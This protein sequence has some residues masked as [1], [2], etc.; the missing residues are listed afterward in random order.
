MGRFVNPDNS[1]FEAAVSANIYVDKP[2]L[3]VIPTELLI[4][5]MLTFAT[6]DHAVLANR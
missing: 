6:A 2:G 1:A 3:L 5:S 4:Q